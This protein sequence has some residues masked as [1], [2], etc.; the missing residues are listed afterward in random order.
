MSDY[1]TTQ[2]SRLWQSRFWTMGL[3]TLIT[4]GLPVNRQER[5]QVLHVHPTKL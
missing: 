4:S 3:L 1:A 5:I 2:A